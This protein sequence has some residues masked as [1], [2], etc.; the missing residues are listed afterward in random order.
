LANS[1]LVPDIMKI[2]LPSSSFEYNIFHTRYLIKKVVTP[3]PL[4]FLIQMF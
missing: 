1:S 3:I 4:A 2:D